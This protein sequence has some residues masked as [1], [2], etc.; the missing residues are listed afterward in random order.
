MFVTHAFQ[1]KKTICR[2]KVCIGLKDTLHTSCWYFQLRVGTSANIQ[3]LL[4]KLKTPVQLTLRVVQ[5]LAEADH[6]LCLQSTTWVVLLVTS[7]SFRT[8]RYRHV[9]QY[10]NFSRNTGIC[11][12]LVGLTFSELPISAANVCSGSVATRLRWS[13]TLCISLEAINFRIRRAAKAALSY[14]RKPGAHFSRH[15][16]LKNTK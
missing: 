4:R 1:K 9:S 13:A 3:K 16:E 6:E 8:V 10:V 7:C 5:G 12:S 2:L 11:R 14:R 15:T